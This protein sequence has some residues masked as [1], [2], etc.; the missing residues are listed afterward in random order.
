M[1]LSIETT[2]F[3]PEQADPFFD[4]LQSY[5]DERLWLALGDSWLELQKTRIDKTAENIPYNVVGASVPGEGSLP[6]RVLRLFDRRHLPVEI[7]TASER[8]L[9][10]TYPIGTKA[11]S[12]EMSHGYEKKKGSSRETPG[13]LIQNL[14]LWRPEQLHTF[15]FW[16]NSYYD[17]TVEV[18]LS[19]GTKKAYLMLRKFG[20]SS[21]DPPYVVAGCTSEEMDIFKY[22][23]G[24]FPRD[25]Q[26]S[27]VKVFASKSELNDIWNFFKDPLSLE[28]F[29]SVISWEYD[30]RRKP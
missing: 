8:K 7:G 18:C 21:E 23:S 30:E 19:A 9:P 28:R 11:L 3:R 29:A 24:M 2:L 10:D 22:L 1:R 26:Q 15:S 16:M 20:H 5:R 17:R 4:N 13:V 12:F 27:P 6:E 25:S 14:P